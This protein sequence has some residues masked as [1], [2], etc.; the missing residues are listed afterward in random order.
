MTGCT[1]SVVE[2]PLT[3]RSGRTS[4]QMAAT[5]NDSSWPNPVGCWARTRFR[6]GGECAP[7]GRATMQSSRGRRTRR[8][9]ARC[10]AIS[11]KF[12][13]R[14]SGEIAFREG[15]SKAMPEGFPKLFLAASVKARSTSSSPRGLARVWTRVANVAAPRLGPERCVSGVPRCAEVVAGT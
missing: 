11:N 10:V 4:V 6:Y 9:S 15:I 8:A 13:R 3:E 7:R 1:S 2:G 12:C 14:L 5:T